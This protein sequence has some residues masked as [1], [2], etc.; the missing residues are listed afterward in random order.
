MDEHQGSN[1]AEHPQARLFYRHK[2]HGGLYEVSTEADGLIAIW[3]QGGAFSV[4]CLRRISPVSMFLRRRL[5]CA[6]AP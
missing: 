5:S 1:K 3:P 4:Y 6:A 2:E